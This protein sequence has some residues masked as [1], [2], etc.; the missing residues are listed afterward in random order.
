M[1]AQNQDWAV[2]LGYVARLLEL[3]YAEFNIRVQRGINAA[4]T[5]YEKYL[6]DLEQSRIQPVIEAG[7]EYEEVAAKDMPEWE[8][9][10]T[11]HGSF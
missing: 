11:A 2:T 9:N 10:E 1:Q 8:L 7:P 4:N 5:D 3:R 6:R